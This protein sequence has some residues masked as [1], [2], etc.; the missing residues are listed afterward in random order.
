MQM[1]KVYKI[2]K[3]I[4]GVVRQKNAKNWEFAVGVPYSTDEHLLIVANNTTPEALNYAGLPVRA[5][6][7]KAY[8][9]FGGPVSM[10]MYD[11]ENVALFTNSQSSFSL[12]SKT[13]HYTNYRVLRGVLNTT[14]SGTLYIPLW[15]DGRYRVEQ[16]DKADLKV[17][18]LANG[19]RMDVLNIKDLKDRDITRKYSLPGIKMAF[20]SG[21][22]YRFFIGEYGLF[23]HSGTYYNFSDTRNKFRKPSN[24][25]DLVAMLEASSLHAFRD[26][27][28]ASKRNEILS[29]S[30][31]CPGSQDSSFN[32]TPETLPNTTLDTS[33]APDAPAKAGCCIM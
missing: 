13:C 28:F 9:I 14:L 2:E 31:K 19:F 16:F 5:I 29:S 15:E 7:Q 30:S 26:E 17:S 33:S 27:C 18:K 23:E 6:L 1:R 3:C 22:E 11:G 25:D 20:D 32:I 4:N 8:D 21:E 12:L 24:F 10:L